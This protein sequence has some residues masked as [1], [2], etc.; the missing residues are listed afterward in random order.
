M[1]FLEDQCIF[2]LELLLVATLSKAY[3]PQWY[4]IKHISE[5]RIKGTTTEICNERKTSEISLLK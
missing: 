3:T 2:V 1:L 4:E 5:G